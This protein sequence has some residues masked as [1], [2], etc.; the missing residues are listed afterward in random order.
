MNCLRN[1]GLSVQDVFCPFFFWIFV[2]WR[3]RG[4]PKFGRKWQHLEAF[5]RSWMILIVFFIMLILYYVS[6]QADKHVQIHLPLCIRRLFDSHSQQLGLSFIRVG[7]GNNFIGHRSFSQSWKLK[8]N[9]S[10]KI[11]GF[12]FGIYDLHSTS[13]SSAST[14]ARFCSTPV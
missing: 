12:I 13:G 1:Q 5:Y 8:I 2:G 10:S 14:V 9:P 6:R 11:V 4:K 7:V 3:P